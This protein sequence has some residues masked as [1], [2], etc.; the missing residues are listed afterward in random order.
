MNCVFS[1][2]PVLLVCVQFQPF[3][4]FLEKENIESSKIHPVHSTVAP[5]CVTDWD[6]DLDLWMTSPDLD[7]P[8]ARAVKP[9]KVKW[10]ENT[11]TDYIVS[12]HV[13]DEWTGQVRTPDGSYCDVS[14][15][16]HAYEVDWASKW[17]EGVG[18]C[19]YYAAT[20]E[21]KPGLILLVKDWKKEQKYYLRAL[22]VCHKHNIQL[23]VI[24]AKTPPE[25]GVK[26]SFLLHDKGKIDVSFIKK[27]GRIYCASERSNKGYGDSFL[28]WKSIHW[29]RSS[30]Q[31]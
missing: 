5:V 16:T 26:S 6:I 28:Q 24:D 29:N 17:P 20:L 9:V 31:Y 8:P 10:D 7:K 1:K 15:P 21:K 12:Q 4:L 22:V 3:M 25:I 27:N 2:L 14:S 19:L 23:I 30:Y 13:N 18:Q 11:W